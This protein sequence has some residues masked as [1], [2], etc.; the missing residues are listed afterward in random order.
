M[1]L[2]PANAAEMPASVGEAA[3][4][5]ADCA[6]VATGDWLVGTVGLSTVPAWHPVRSSAAADSHAVMPRRREELIDG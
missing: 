1:I 2:E 3:I 4:I 5:D 6:G